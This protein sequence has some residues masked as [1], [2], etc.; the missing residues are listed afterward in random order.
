MFG[1]AASPERRVVAIV[2]PNRGDHLVVTIGDRLAEGYEGIGPCHVANRTLGGRL[3]LKT[4]GVDE[5]ARAADRDSGNLF[6][7]GFRAAL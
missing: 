7:V 1:K 5:R 4:I 2:L 3:C 6:L